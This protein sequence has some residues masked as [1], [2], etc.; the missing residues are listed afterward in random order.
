M[1]AALV[2]VY[3]KCRS[4]K[5]AERT[6]WKL[7]EKDVFLYNVMIAMHIQNGQK[8]G[9]RQLYRRMHLEGLI[10][11]KVTLISTLCTCANEATLTEG[12]QIHASFVGSKFETDINVCNAV[13]SMY[14][15]GGSLR[16]AK[17]LFN[18]MTKS[19]VIS[20][21]AMIACYVQ[22][23]H[24]KQALLV[25]EQMRQQKLK[26]TKVTF[27]TIL[28]GCASQEALLEGRRLHACIVDSGFDS[29]LTVGNALVTMYGKCAS[30][31]DA[32]KVFDE[33]PERDVVSWTSILA[34]YVV[35]GQCMAAFQLFTEMQSEVVLDKAALVSIVSACTS[36]SSQIYEEDAA[37]V[38]RHA[39]VCYKS[40]S[41]DVAQRIFDRT[42]TRD[43]V[44]WNAMIVAYA[45][46]GYGRAALGLFGQMQ[47]EN[48]MPDKHICASILSAC[49]SLGALTE[50][51]HMHA[52]IVGNGFEMD[53][54]VENA[55]VNLHGKCGSMED[56]Q[57]LFDNMPQHDAV[58][59]TAII[60]AYAM[61]G[62]SQTALQ[63]YQQML[64]EGVMPD[65]VTLVSIFSACSSHAALVQGKQMHSC[66]MTNAMDTD[67]VT[68][69]ALINMY[70]KCGSLQIARK[71]FDR[72]LK[73][74]VS[75]WN[76]MITGYAQNG[77]G[78]DALHLF[79]Q[80]QQEI[81]SPNSVTLVSVL[82]A[83]SHGGLSYEVWNHFASMHPDYGIKP[84][85]EHY[86]IM[87]DLLGRVGRLN[88]AEGLV[89]NMPCQPTVVSWM[90]F[91]GACKYQLDLE[92]AT[93]AANIIFELDPQNLAPY[94][95][96]AN[97]YAA[98]GQVDDAT[99]ITNMRKV[100]CLKGQPGSVCDLSKNLCCKWPRG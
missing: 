34:A 44:L 27:V 80:M 95:I 36:Q 5:D 26:P 93:Y 94:V 100:Q 55:L 38:D 35:N 8:S 88:L 91:L 62:K 7:L 90:T 99:L 20:W 33:M 72:M 29:N 15:K 3:R 83:C 59:W 39:K 57:K 63:L 17:T 56:A 77:L 43:V 32:R 84:V 42:P 14:S 21:N 53:I 49:A 12:R 45:R 70:A 41:L 40:G 24:F 10:P 50:G 79:W 97:I 31:K 78:E 30:L 73:R 76:V 46:T 13:V 61:L 4:P 82:S 22:N 28:S 81:V 74:D 64:L 54:I 68:G 58:T 18:K 66:T 67:L 89:R 87:I 85:V 47:R 86:N 51:K 52:W 71:V 98:S 9:A 75:S 60:G 1:G 19:D 37:W 6:F 16:D 2:N 65:R 92:R 48:V 11:D 96:L 69:N 23:R 25:F